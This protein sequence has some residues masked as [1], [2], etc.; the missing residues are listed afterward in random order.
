MTKNTKDYACDL[1]RLI[2]PVARTKDFL[3]LYQE[4][5]LTVKGYGN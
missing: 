1:L 4:A 5:I 2:P 3:K